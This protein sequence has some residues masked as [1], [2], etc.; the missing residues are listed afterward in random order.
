LGVGFDLA[1]LRFPSRITPTWCG[2]FEK[3]KEAIKRR[4][5]SG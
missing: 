4:S 2:V 1:H 3:S 5:Y